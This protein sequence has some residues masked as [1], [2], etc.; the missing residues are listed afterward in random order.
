MRGRR[1]WRVIERSED[2]DQPIVLSLAHTLG[3]VDVP[4][5]AIRWIAAV[6]KVTFLIDGKLRTYPATDVEVCFDAQVGPQFYALTCNILRPKVR[7]KTLA[8]IIGGECIS[9]PIVSE[10]LGISP[11]FGISAYSLEEAEALARRLWPGRCRPKL[12]LIAKP[13]AG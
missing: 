1:S 2:A 3:R 5:R 4:M 11:I 13:D 8:I 6:N 9:R 10:P 7:D 12:S